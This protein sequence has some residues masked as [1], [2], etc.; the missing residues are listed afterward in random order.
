[1]QYLAVPLLKSGAKDLFF[2]S[3]VVYLSEGVFIY[4]LINLGL[5]FS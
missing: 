2:K 1:M 3:I 5:Y 4:I